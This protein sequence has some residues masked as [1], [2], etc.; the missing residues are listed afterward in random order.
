MPVRVAQENTGEPSR[1][2]LCHCEQRQEVAQPT[3][4]FYLKVIAI[5]LTEIEQCK[6]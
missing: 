5:E 1:N 3:C 2:F 4:S 6:C